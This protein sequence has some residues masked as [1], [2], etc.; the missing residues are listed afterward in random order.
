MKFTLNEVY[1][2]TVN[3]YLITSAHK[4]RALLLYA[5]TMKENIDALFL[6]KWE[7]EY[8][9]AKLFKQSQKKSGTLL[10]TVS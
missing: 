4:Y 7:K 10:G 3:A 8:Q 2:S 5:S 6:L 9:K 1:L